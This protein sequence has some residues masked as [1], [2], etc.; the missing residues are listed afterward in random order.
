[1]NDSFYKKISEH[2][3][4]VIKSAEEAM[5]AQQLHLESLQD[6]I[7]V[8]KEKNEVQDKHISELK[9]R[10]EELVEISNNQQDLIDIQEKFIHQLTS[11]INGIGA[12]KENEET[13]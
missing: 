4:E 7:K 1:M 5:E 11:G 13:P 9:T 3:T 12:S 10:M 2:Q 6:I 8:L